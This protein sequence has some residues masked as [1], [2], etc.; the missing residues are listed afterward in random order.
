MHHRFFWLQQEIRVV[1]VVHDHVSCSWDWERPPSSPLHEISSCISR[2]EIPSSHAFHHKS[3]KRHV[4]TE[5]FRI[6]AFRLSLFFSS[7]SPVSMIAM[8]GVKS[9]Q[10]YAIFFGSFSSLTA[11]TQALTRISHTSCCL[12]KCSL[13]ICHGYVS[14]ASSFPSPPLLLIL[15]LNLLPSHASCYSSRVLFLHLTDDWCL[16][17]GKSRWN[18][19]LLLLQQSCRVMSTLH[20][21]LL[22]FFAIGSS[23]ISCKAMRGMILVLVSLFAFLCLKFF[24]SVVSMWL[25]PFSVYLVAFNIWYTFTP[26]LSLLTLMTGKRKISFSLRQR[27]NKWRQE[28]VDQEGA[29]DNED[30]E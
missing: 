4:K 29:S 3:K 26:S 14:C 12:M 28:Q 5:R 18:S 6:D 19:F 21:S 24:S 30:N 10:N 17:W 25:L 1:V 27:I 22:V 9:W 15:P 8:S 7:V 11:S 2:Q 16:A 23:F 20:T 13:E